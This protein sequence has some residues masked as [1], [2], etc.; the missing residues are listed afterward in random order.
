MSVGNN[1][2]F[3]FNAPWGWLLKGTSLGVVL[4]FAALAFLEKVGGWSLVLLFL[5]LLVALPFIVRGYA[6]SDDMLIIRRLGWETRFPL[7]D[8]KS[9]DVSP[10]VMRG[11]IRLCGNGGIFS[12]TGLYR[13][14]ALGNFRSFANDGGKTVVLRFAKQ[15]IVVSPDN[16][17]KFVETIRPR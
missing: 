6:V 7:A 3:S 15:T 12:F 17:E 11:A 2:S 1:K 14:K 4:L 10:N 9:V 13:N 5:I 8:L 16:P